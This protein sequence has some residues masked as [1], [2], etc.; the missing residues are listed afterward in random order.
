MNVNKRQ[1]RLKKRFIK[2]YDPEN[3]KYKSFHLLPDEEF[4]VDSYEFVKDPLKDPLCDD[5]CPTIMEQAKSSTREMQKSLK[6]GIKEYLEDRCVV[7]NI[8]KYRGPK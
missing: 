7:N 4:P 5:D 6:D 2:L 3:K 8:L 1:K